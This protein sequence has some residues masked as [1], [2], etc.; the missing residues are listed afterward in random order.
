MYFG[1]FAGLTESIS[2]SYRKD[3]SL[4]VCQVCAY[5][6]N[7]KSHIQSHLLVHS[8]EKTLC[9]QHLPE[10]IQPKGEFKSTQANSRS[11]SA[12]HMRTLWSKILSKTL[13]G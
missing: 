11:N 1:L 12:I 9:L 7:H 6:T 10:N 8:K 2:V 5:C 4:F 3:G 13:S